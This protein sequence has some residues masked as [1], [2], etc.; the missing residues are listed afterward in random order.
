M[1]ANNK[2]CR[3]CILCVHQAH[4]IL[5]G[6]KIIRVS[7]EHITQTHSVCSNGLYHYCNLF[8]L[9]YTACVCDLLVSFAPIRSLVVGEKRNRNVRISYAHSC[10]VDSQRLW[11]LKAIKPPKHL[12]FAVY[13]NFFIFICPIFI[14]AAFYESRN[15]LLVRARARLF[16][17]F[18]Y[19]F[20]QLS[21]AQMRMD[22]RAKEKAS[23]QPTTHNHHYCNHPIDST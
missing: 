20:F 6:A 7:P 17:P 11:S 3:F 23:N 12:H 14:I 19:S 21:T 4:Y 1:C 5:D 10:I 9:R 18:F 22:T 2:C 15:S 16:F 8:L 13:S